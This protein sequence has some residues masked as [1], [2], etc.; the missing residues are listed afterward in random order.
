MKLR[1]KIFAMAIGALVF[2]STSFASDLTKDLKTPFDVMTNPFDHME[3][4]A[5]DGQTAQALKTLIEEC[6]FRTVTKNEN[7]EAWGTAQLKQ[8]C[9]ARAS[10][11]LVQGPYAGE[12]K[13]IIHDKGLKLL[14]LAW[15][16]SHSDGGDEQAL[17]IYNKQGQRIAVYP[18]LYADGN[19]IE[20]LAHALGVDIP[21]V[22]QSK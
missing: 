12:N 21:Q 9:A 20:A 5:L 13:L 8:E 10:L 22:L 7:Y 4:V 1:S 11:K 16:G 14:A 2:S 19:V 3:E 17:G 15:D 6:T 18:S